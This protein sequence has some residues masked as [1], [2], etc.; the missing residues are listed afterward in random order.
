M[1]GVWMVLPFLA[2]GVWGTLPGAT[3][4]YSDSQV[5]W[6]TTERL[7]PTQNG[8]S[9]RVSLARLMEAQ[10]ASPCRIGPVSADP[11]T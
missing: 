5:I 7:A 2:L 1:A 10:P 9:T 4:F 6:R 8:E 11:S 3:P